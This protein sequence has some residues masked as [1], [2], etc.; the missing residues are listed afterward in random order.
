MSEKAYNIFIYIYMYIND[1]KY[2]SNLRVLIESEN[3]SD[4]D[5]EVYID[6][7][8]LKEDFK[9]RFGDVDNMHVA[10]WLVPQFDIKIDNKGYESDLE[11]ERIEMHVDIRAKAL[12]KCKNVAD[13]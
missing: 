13:Y 11:D 12:F 4:C 2:F 9:I 7:D 10:E 3:T 8:K 1:I 5:L 6:L